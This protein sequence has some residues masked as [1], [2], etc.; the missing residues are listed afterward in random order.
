MI[1]AILSSISALAKKRRE[2][3]QSTFQLG[4]RNLS[5]AL[6]LTATEQ[7]RLNI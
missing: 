6:I 3:A 1:Y 2:C 4:Q 5:N 7:A